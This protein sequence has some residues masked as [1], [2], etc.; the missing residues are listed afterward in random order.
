M[1]LIHFSSKWWRRSPI[2]SSRCVMTY[3]QHD[4]L[5]KG[6]NLG[7]LKSCSPLLRV[8]SHSGSTG[9]GLLMTGGQRAKRAF[10][11]HCSSSQN[12]SSS[13]LLAGKDKSSSKE[14]STVGIVSE[15]ILGK[16]KKFRSIFLPR[17][18]PTNAHVFISNSI[19]RAWA[20]CFC[21]RSSLLQTHNFFSF[22]FFTLEIS[23]CALYC[24]FYAICISRLWRGWAR[25]HH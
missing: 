15:G 17:L 9:G 22:I 7:I 18:S 10:L 11:N 14:K 4:L 2:S 5:K 19:Y 13:S 23:T 21:R 20:F 24:N 25:V 12:S 1:R 16:T 8:C 3:E 6:T